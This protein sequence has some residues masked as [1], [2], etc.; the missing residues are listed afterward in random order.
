M[1]EQELSSTIDT[2]PSLQVHCASHDMAGKPTG[3]NK[4][5]IA[6]TDLSG[7]RLSECVR[8]GHEGISTGVLHAMTD[9]LA[10]CQGYLKLL[11]ACQ[12]ANLLM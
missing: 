9:P 3:F 12:E 10:R 8:N 1:N 7:S 6:R 5:C 2:V 11:P 4:F